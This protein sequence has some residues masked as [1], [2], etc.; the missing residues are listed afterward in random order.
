M[1]GEK[2]TNHTPLQPAIGHLR[3]IP[4]PNLTSLHLTSS[5]KPTPLLPNNTP[6]PPPHRSPHQNNYPYLKRTLFYEKWRST[7]TTQE[8]LMDPE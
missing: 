4:I 7:A 3:P 1:V 8:E 2:P 5:S 6:R